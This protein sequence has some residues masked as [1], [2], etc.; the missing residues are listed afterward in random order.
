MPKKQSFKKEPVAMQTTVK[1]NKLIWLLPSIL[2]LL[3]GVMAVLGI[4]LS[5]SLKSVPSVTAIKPDVPETEKTE[6]PVVPKTRFRSESKE[7]S[8]DSAKSMLKDNG[9]FASDWNKSAM[10][11]PN[12]YELQHNGEVVFDSASGLTWQQ[13]GSDEYMRYERAKLYVA[14]LNRKRVAGYS[15]WRLPTLEEAMSLM[16]PKT[17]SD[18]LYIGSKFDSKQKWICTSDIERASS[19]WVVDF[20]YGDCFYDYGSYFLGGYYVRAVR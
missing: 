16:E 2:V 3:I 13:S 18:G 14:D 5:N 7:L 9:F 12:N 20:L 15:D 10:G 4:Y 11:I 19:V 6:K 17:N 8:T 1:K